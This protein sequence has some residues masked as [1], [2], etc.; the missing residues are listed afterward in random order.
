MRG[1]K[2]TMKEKKFDIL[3]FFQIIFVI[4]VVLISIYSLVTE[5]FNLQPVSFIL[6]SAL[7]LTIALREYKKTQSLLWSIF[8]LCISLFSL[9][10]AIEGIMIN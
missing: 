1:I 4:P 5:N 2:I 7:F 9:Y 6:M 3:M 8:Y 10:V